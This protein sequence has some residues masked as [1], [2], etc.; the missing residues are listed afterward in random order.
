MTTLEMWGAALAL[1]LLCGLALHH[2]GATAQSK[3][4]HGC[5]TGIAVAWVGFVVTMVRR[6]FDAG[7]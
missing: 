3:L 4:F 2:T 5:T 6:L 1:L 7:G